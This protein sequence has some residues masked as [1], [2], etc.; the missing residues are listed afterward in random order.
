MCF[1]MIWA[2]KNCF[3]AKLQLKVTFVIFLGYFN[4]EYVQSL[5]LI[6]ISLVF[7]RQERSYCQICWTQAATTDFELTT[8]KTGAAGKFWYQAFSKYFQY[9]QFAE[10]L[11]WKY[12]TT[13]SFQLWWKFESDHSSSFVLL[14]FNK[15]TNGRC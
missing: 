12:Q 8:S 11:S 10:Q 3:F 15:M 7:N 2:N 9:V 1:D 5:K 6:L 13:M 14:L 4:L